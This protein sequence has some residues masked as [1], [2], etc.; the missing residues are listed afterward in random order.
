MRAVLSITC[1]EDCTPSA[2]MQTLPMRPKIDACRTSASSA[3]SN[4]R[5]VARLATPS[6]AP[7]WLLSV[8]AALRRWSCCVIVAAKK[9]AGAP[10]P[11]RPVTFVSDRTRWST[12]VAGPSRRA[13]AGPGWSA[14][15]ARFAAIVRRLDGLAVSASSA[16]VAMVRSRTRSPGR[17]GRSRG[18]P[19]QALLRRQ[20]RQGR[21]GPAGQRAACRLAILL[22]ET[23]SASWRH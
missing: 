16:L 8:S 19:A 13:P 7:I 21:F 18:Q 22:A 14:G 2:R 12:P 10:A 1:V 6:T 17:S 11:P 23:F 3:S 4:W 9:C 5:T 20:S 15:S